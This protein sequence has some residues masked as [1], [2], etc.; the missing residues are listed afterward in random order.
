[1][2]TTFNLPPI[3]RGDETHQLAQIRDYLVAMSKQLN[4]AMT[5][6][7]ESNFTVGTTAYNVVSGNG[8]GITEAVE[9]QTQALQALIMST[10]ESVELSIEDITQ[11]LNSHATYISHFGTFEE[12]ITAD[13]YESAT[14]MTW[15]NKYNAKITTE[16]QNY[17]TSTAGY[18][19]YGIVDY[20]DTTPIYGIAVGQDLHDGTNDD[21]YPQIV[22][23][24]RAVY[25]ATG[26]SFYQGNAKVAYMSNQKLYITSA[27]ITDKLQLGL[28]NDAAKW[29]ISMNGG[30]TIKWVG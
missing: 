19:R 21:G 23:S 1:M 17:I 2:N 27:H 10:A 22:A 12:D 4:I 8:D 29:E 28:N 5:S 26:L 7:D 16:L 15:A 6:L 11:T 9:N 24:F 18:I 14:G 3:L 25:T 30:F 20:D 13:V